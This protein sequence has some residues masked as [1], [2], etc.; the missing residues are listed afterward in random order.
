MRGTV[1]AGT[2]PLRAWRLTVQRDG[3]RTSREIAKGTDAILDGALATLR[4]GRAMRLRPGHR[5]TATLRATDA[6]GRSSEVTT[7][8]RIPRLLFSRIPLPDRFDEGGYDH[9]ISGD[10]T[11]IALTRVGLNDIGG[12]Q[13]N[14]WLFD[15]ATRELLELENGDSPTLSADGKVLLFWDLDEGIFLGALY[16]IVTKKRTG[17]RRAY[18]PGFVDAHAK[19]FTSI[20][21]VA[22]RDVPDSGRGVFVLDIA[23]ENITRIS[24]GPLPQYVDELAISSE[25]PFTAFTSAT[26]FDPTASTGDHSQVFLY[27]ERDRS[28]R[29]LTNR[30]DPTVAAAGPTLSADGST[31]AYKTDGGQVRVLELPSGRERFL[32]DVSEHGDVLGNYFLSADGQ[33]LAFSSTADLDP[34]VGNEAHAPQLFRLDLVNGTFQQVTDAEGIAFFTAIDATART[35]LLQFGGEMQIGDEVLLLRNTRV[36]P[37]RRNNIPPVL[38]IPDV[39]RTY[40]GRTTTHDFAASDPEGDPI[41]MY[42]RLDAPDT[43]VGRLSDFSS[44]FDD[45]G[46]G[47]AQLTLTPNANQ[48]GSYRLHVAAFD[49]AGAVTLKVGS[50]VVA[51]LHAD[52]D[53]NC[54][55]RI[56]S[57]DAEALFPAILDSQPLPP[58]IASGD[59]NGDGRL[60]VADL[61]AL[62]ARDV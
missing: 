58:C 8:F 21:S 13:T 51:A 61:I 20:S 57:D 52:G 42:V 23:S 5:Y 32:L 34:T 48:I 39:L 33:I 49:E 1:R 7:H 4:L 56:D 19:R 27:D 55:G 46:D 35:L 40:E 26:P 15:T 18:F 36:V 38:E 29:Q 37:R 47:T 14:I 43:S 12:H 41:T 30:D 2:N 44:V 53:G 10:G 31:L 17:V 3:A 62:L 50:V 24:Q 16:N 28:L 45:H 11:R 6:A 54:D 9:V 25:G 59:V 60:S 22:T